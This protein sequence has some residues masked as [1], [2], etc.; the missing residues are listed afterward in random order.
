MHAMT[1]ASA[2]TGRRGELAEAALTV[3]ADGGL[4][5]LTHRAVDAA[6][7]VPVGTTSAYLRT[8]AALVEALA[9]HVA[10]TLVVGVE[11]LTAR[12]GPQADPAEVVRRTSA[13]LRGWVGQPDLVL[14]R[15][16]LLLESIRSAELRSV[17][18]SW[19]ERLVALVTGV[20]AAKG[21]P[22]AGRRAEAVVSALEGVLTGALLQPVARRRAYVE[23]MVATVLGGLIAGEGAPVQ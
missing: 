10:G 15:A 4:R 8:R 20:A 13:L 19:R 12:L 18:L 7:G 23:D 3:V 9:E 1:P 5:A 6:A 14:V 21:V 11:E 22:D 17:F 2:L 16:E